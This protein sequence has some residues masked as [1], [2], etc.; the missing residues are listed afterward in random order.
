VRAHP[1]RIIRVLAASITD[2]DRELRGRETWWGAARNRGAAAAGP[3][4]LAAGFLARG[5]S[6]SGRRD[7][8]LK[9]C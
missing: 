4:L 7:L 2:S 5:A 8:I 3:S 9:T 6:I 1:G